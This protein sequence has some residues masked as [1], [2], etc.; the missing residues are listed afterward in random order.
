MNPNRIFSSH[1]MLASRAF[2]AQQNDVSWC[3]FFIRHRSMKDRITREIRLSSLNRSQIKN[4]CW[5]LRLQHLCRLRLE[6]IIITNTQ[7]GNQNEPHFLWIV[8]KLRQSMA[9]WLFHK[10]QFTTNQNY[11]L[12]KV[13]MC[14]PMAT[15]PLVH[16]VSVWVA[17]RLRLC[18]INTF[19]G[20]SR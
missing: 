12:S 18:R 10:Y 20:H 2:K 1:H 8:V 19:F 3:F 7:N 11:Y 4:D 15:W 13:K 17:W 14:I 9:T 5:F 6:E 16:I